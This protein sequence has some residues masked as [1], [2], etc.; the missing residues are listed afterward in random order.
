MCHKSLVEIWKRV[1]EVV[2][3][4]ALGDDDV[5]G[6][7]EAGELAGGGV[8]D[9]ED[10]KLRGAAGH[11]GGVLESEGASAALERSSNAFHGD[12]AGGAFDGRAS[13]EHL[14]FAGAFE[15]AAELFVNGHAAEGG[16]GGFVVRGLRG[17]FYVKCSGGVGGHGG[18]F[19]AGSWNL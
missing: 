5:H 1:G 14:A 19:L 17:Q 2:G 13:G 7:G 9:D 15:V 6:A 3:V 18:A 11:S 8:G 4:F 10:G 12:V 16:V